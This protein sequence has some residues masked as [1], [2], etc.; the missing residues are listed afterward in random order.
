MIL[1][2][3]LTALL[4]VFAMNICKRTTDNVLALLLPMWITFPKSTSTLLPGNHLICLQ[5]RLVA[6][7]SSW[8]QRPLLCLEPHLH[9]IS[10]LSKQNSQST[11][12]ET[13]SNPC[14]NI[15]TASAVTCKPD[16]QLLW[17]KP[18][19]QA[20]L[21][22]FFNL[23]MSLK[24]LNRDHPAIY[25]WCHRLTVKHSLKFSPQLIVAQ[26]EVLCISSSLLIPSYKLSDISNA[27]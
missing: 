14:S 23:F 5:C 27:Y 19:Q 9:N 4:I 22:F 13:C 17:H 25:I 24:V 10:G 11:C 20:L 15:Q 6:W 21:S 2:T 18:L 12:C 7:H 8:S 16:K 26:S 3:T 1:C